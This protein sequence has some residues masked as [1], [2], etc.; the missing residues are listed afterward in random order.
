MK[1]LTEEHTPAPTSIGWP[2]GRLITVPP[3]QLDECR[4]CKDFKN[5]SCVTFCKSCGGREVP[6]FAGECPKTKDTSS[7]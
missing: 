4:K 5:C 2:V 1:E 6:T 7:K 3:G